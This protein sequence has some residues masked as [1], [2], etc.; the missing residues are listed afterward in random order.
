[1]DNVGSN[2]NKV[3]SHLFTVLHV[4]LVTEI[5]VWNVSR[6]SLVQSY[7]SGHR[8]N[9]FC[10][11]FTPGAE[12]Q[13]Y[14]CAADS[15]VRVHDLLAGVSKAYHCHSG[16][17]HKLAV[18]Q[19]QPDVILSCSEDST[20][21]QFD[22]RIPHQCSRLSTCKNC[23]VTVTNKKNKLCGI[24]SFA[25][26]PQ[27]EQ[28]FVVASRD[29]TL[30]VFDRRKLSLGYESRFTPV[31]ELTPDIPPNNSPFCSG[32]TS[33][34]YSVDGERIIG[35]YSGDTIYGFDLSDRIWDSEHEKVTRFET[36][37]DFNMEDKPTRWDK[38]RGSLLPKLG[39]PVRDREHLESI[40][41]KDDEAKDDTEL[42]ENEDET[43]RTLTSWKMKWSVKVVHR[44]ASCAACLLRIC[45]VV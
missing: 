1:M 34:V 36:A 13:I 10:T 6:Q 33:V 11:L 31:L 43:K 41:M 3:W 4:F 14:S 15:Q 24:N 29:Q 39:L 25:L 42:A 23:L 18:S 9:I 28:Y 35:S 38:I 20:V 44:S 32:V 5:K 21:R 12:Y 16:M 40:E 26:N 17:T 22:T 45:F 27:D 30:R 37:T 7:S 2:I 19:N 8:G